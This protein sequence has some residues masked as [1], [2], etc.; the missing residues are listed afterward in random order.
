ME[1]LYGYC[2]CGCGHIAPIAKN[3]N[4]R[5]DHVK[6]KPI[7]FIRGHSLEYPRG[8]T[9]PRWKGGKKSDAEGRTWIHMPGHKKAQKNYVLQYVLI[10][11]KLLGKSL[12][13]GVMI[14][15]FDGIP[16]NDKN[17]NLVICENNTYHRLLHQRKRAYD[18]CGHANWKK[19]HICKEYDEVENLYLSPNKN[20]SAYHKRC[21]KK[22]Q[23]ATRRK[24]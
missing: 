15:H 7:R 8:K 22:Y 16:S 13:N 4:K 5:W 17:K 23:R 10:V 19:C 6:G 11:E 20:S 1:L 3:T 18:A 12:P 24:H 14:H 9:H 2:Q 21:K